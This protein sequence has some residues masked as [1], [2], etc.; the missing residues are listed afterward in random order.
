L[1]KTFCE[2]Y[3]A[4]SEAFNG[5]AHDAKAQIFGST[6]GVWFSTEVIDPSVHNTIQYD[7][8]NVVF[9]R[10]GPTLFGFDGEPLATNLKRNVEV[11]KANGPALNEALVT[12][13]DW[14]IHTPSPV[15]IRP[16]DESVII[17]ACQNIDGI[18][19]HSRVLPHDS[20]RTYLF[21][22]LKDD[23]QRYPLINSALRE[24]VAKNLANV[25][26]SPTLSQIT[27]GLDRSI[28]EYANQ[29]VLG[30]K[31]TVTKLMKPIEE[32][33]HKFGCAVMS[34]LHSSYIVD[35]NSE[36]QRLRKYVRECIDKIQN[37]NDQKGKQ[38]LER[39]I[40]KLGSVDVIN[41]SMEGIVFSDANRIY[42]ITGAFAPVNQICAY[43]KYKNV[44]EHNNKQSL[45][46][47]ITVG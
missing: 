45:A 3:S 47:F 28:K 8:R 6:G 1:L 19:R 17:N 7:D 42:K 26:N 14:R 39:N 13:N 21:K 41:S 4:L 38:I 43:L 5:L 27:G 35:G 25:P 15:T 33:V 36:I 12:H 10:Y 30:G 37:S 11:L 32:V 31:G 23:F 9:H 40:W 20:L 24:M 2:A 22:R 29:M 44:F 18:V 34:G 16:V 46:T